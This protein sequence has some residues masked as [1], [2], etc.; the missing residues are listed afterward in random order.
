MKAFGVGWHLLLAASLLFLAK[1]AAVSGSPS[2]SASGSKA[3]T[4][5]K[6]KKAEKNKFLHKNHYHPDHPGAL[7][8]FDI[9]RMTIMT[10][11]LQD[12]VVMD[13][14]GADIS[15]KRKYKFALRDLRLCL[16]KE[17]K[18]TCTAAFSQALKY[19][20]EGLKGDVNGTHAYIGMGM[21]LNVEKISKELAYLRK[22]NIREEKQQLIKALLEK[23]SL[24]KKSLE[25]TSN[26]TMSC[27]IGGL[28]E[29]QFSNQD[30]R[31]IREQFEAM[32]NIAHLYNGDDLY[33]KNFTWDEEV[34][35]IHARNLEHIHGRQ[36]QRRGILGRRLFGRIHQQCG[37]CK[38]R[39]LK[40]DMT[41]GRGKKERR[42]HAKNPKKP[43]LDLWS[44]HDE[45][46]TDVCMPGYHKIEHV[47]GDLANLVAMKIGSQEDN[48][49]FFVSC[50]FE[51]V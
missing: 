35:E 34:N 46:P 8:T 22:K 48:K 29:D 28:N 5:K 9:K 14:E 32:I 47:D 10:E 19:L 7:T 31:D 13:V 30:F 24:A 17:K 36:L 42:L 45:V 1:D 2:P 18:E 27:V 11:K 33:I 51:S 12:I 38:D 23:V 26:P 6:A 49:D 4:A 15:A 44:K 43:L 16:E 20:N 3:K 41:R 21:G 37:S 25:Q 40:S 50:C 39:M